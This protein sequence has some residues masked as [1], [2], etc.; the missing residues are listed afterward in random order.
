ML[1]IQESKPG[2]KDC[3]SNNSQS[4]HRIVYLCNSKQLA[5]YEMEGMQGYISAFFHLPK[6]KFLE[7]ILF[8]I[9]LK[10]KKHWFLLR[11]MLKTLTEMWFFHKIWLL[12]FS[13][14]NQYK[15]SS[16]C[17]ERLTEVRF[18]SLHYRDE[19]QKIMLILM[20]ETQNV[21]KNDCLQEPWE[22]DSHGRLWCFVNLCPFQWLK[23]K[24]W[25]CCQAKGIKYCVKCIYLYGTSLMILQ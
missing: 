5:N 19:I 7:R 17:V 12:Y 10:S 15:P 20:E 24:Y 21:L 16:V 6:A 11:N 8:F 18:S 2:T 23:F 14:L 3:Q 9:V 22:I 4:W 13:I 25:I 1:L